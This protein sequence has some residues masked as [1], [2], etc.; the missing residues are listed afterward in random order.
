MRR[1][2]ALRRAAMATI[3]IAAIWLIAVKGGGW[4]QS[5]PH[6]T[7]LSGWGLFGLMLILT[8]YNGRK[9]LPFIPLLSSRLWLQVHLYLGLFTGVVFLLH[10]RW[11]WPSG[12][13]EA[14]LA[15]LFST[16]TGSGIVGWW[17]SRALPPRLTTV[18]GEVPYDRIPEVVRAL[19]E[20]AER[21]ALGAIPAARTTTLSDFY[22]SR[23]AGF[24]A[25]PA[26]FTAHLRGSRRPLNRMLAQIGEVRRFVNSEEGK[27]LDQLADLVRSKDA[28]DLQ[29]SL[30]LV[31]K[32]WLFVHI[33][34]T[35]S[36]LLASVAHIV[37]VYAFSGGA[38]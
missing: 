29:R 36:L 38:R 31:L 7:Y 33:P 25:A 35:Y 18:G 15:F 26:N 8:A 6:F 4:Q 23:L 5:Y 22:A 14:A 17:L 28:V 20:D 10:L 11:S 37:V 19:R 24:F 3:L 1:R 2:L 27:S 13:F 34:L 21:V 12:W 32:G 9:K 16:V 30:Q